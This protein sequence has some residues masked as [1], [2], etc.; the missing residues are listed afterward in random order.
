MNAAIM[1]WW[2]TWSFGHRRF[3]NLLP[4]LA[5]GIALLYDRLA[6][7]R[8]LFLVTIGLLA[9]WNQLFLYQYQNGLIP[10]SK[11]PTFTEFVTDKFGLSRVW[12]AQLHVNTAITAFR[13]ND[14]P[15]FLN[16]ANTAYRTYPEYRNSR[17]VY[18]VAGTALQDGETAES[19]F[20]AWHQEE[21]TNLVATWGLADAWIRANRRDEAARLF[22]PN[23]WGKTGREVVDLIRTGNEPLMDQTF[24]NFY[25]AELDSVY[26]H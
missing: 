7:R 1:D 13:R 9:V 16:Q 22:E 5:W 10:R 15:N 20:A 25:R 21:P 18:S 4:F 23:L 3:V 17:L 24:F 11:S 19:L 6:A 12:E 26:I 8:R 14:F 2:G